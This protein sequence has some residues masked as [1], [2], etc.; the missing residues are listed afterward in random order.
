MCCEEE[1]EKLMFIDSVARARGFTEYRVVLAVAPGIR[2]FTDVA[3]QRRNRLPKVTMLT[4]PE[5]GFIPKPRVKKGL[6][7]VRPPPSRLWL[8]FWAEV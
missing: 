4:T 8:T 1:D 6:S 7:R 2:L 5:S 3:V